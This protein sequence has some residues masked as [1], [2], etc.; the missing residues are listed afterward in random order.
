MPTDFNAPYPERP[1]VSVGEDLADRLLATSMNVLAVEGV[2]DRLK[3]MAI[4]ADAGG[5]VGLA[6]GLRELETNLRVIV[7]KAE[8]TIESHPQASEV[9]PGRKRDQTHR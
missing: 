2:A 3:W 9:H 5:Y 7:T 1:G 8:A 4:G 6:E